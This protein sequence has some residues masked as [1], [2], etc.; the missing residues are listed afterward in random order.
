M[1]P[2]LLKVS[3]HPAAHLAAY[4]RQRMY[5]CVKLGFYIIKSRKRDFFPTG[6][7]GQRVDLKD[8]KIPSHLLFGKCNLLGKY[9]NST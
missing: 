3:G 2:F 7:E 4:C 5:T 8:S 1:P 6:T 9:F